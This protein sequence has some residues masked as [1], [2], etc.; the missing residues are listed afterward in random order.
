MKPVNLEDHRPKDPPGYGD[1]E[2]Q[3][4]NE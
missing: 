3:E 1:E 2:E 4:E